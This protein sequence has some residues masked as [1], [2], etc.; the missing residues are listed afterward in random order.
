MNEGESHTPDS[1]VQIPGLPGVEYQKP[2]PPK[3]PQPKPT[4]TPKVD[5]KRIIERIKKL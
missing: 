4:P 2:P 1:I 5:I 3:P